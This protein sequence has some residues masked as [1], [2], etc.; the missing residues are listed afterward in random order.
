MVK[1]K[2]RKIYKTFLK[3]Q[4]DH[5]FNITA[6]CINSTRFVLSS[7][8]ILPF[9]NLQIY[10]RSKLHFIIYQLRISYFSYSER[11]NYLVLVN[12]QIVCIRLFHYKLKVRIVDPPCFFER[13]SRVGLVLDSA[14]SVSNL[15]PLGHRPY[16]R[17]E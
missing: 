16:D 14:R 4:E 7:Q 1:R 13:C 6:Y 15:H 11:R 10:E 5:N 12:V 17:I 9:S 2:I 3:R 8:Q